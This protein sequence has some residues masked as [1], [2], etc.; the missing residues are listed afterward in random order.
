[1]PRNA[2]TVQVP[3]STSNLGSGFDTLGLAVRLSNGVTVRRQPGVDIE[4]AGAMPEEDRSWLRE[5]LTT[6][7]ARF[8]QTCGVPPFGARVTLSGNVPVARGLGA[9]ATVRVGLLAG[10]NAL[11]GRPA[12]R[13]DLLAMAT[14]LEG[15]P[16][17]ASPALYGGFTVSGRVAD[18][19]RIRVRCLSF[20]VQ[21]RLKIVILIPRFGISTED[22]RRLLPRTYSKSDAAHALNRSALITAAL[23]GGRYE[24]LRGLFD[25]RMHQPYRERLLPALPA[26]IRAGETAGALGGFLSGSG[27]SIICLT[28]AQPEAVARAMRRQLPES[29]VKIVTAENRGLRVLSPASGGRTETRKAR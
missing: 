11:A 3:A 24:D 5:A 16:D 27:S 20:P 15:H 25:D 23:A 21:P 7:A 12:T 19:D 8:F 26:V 18:G 10:L 4:P 29:S 1:M 28:L 14:A 2:V 22:A 6:A 9:S 17:N 13:E